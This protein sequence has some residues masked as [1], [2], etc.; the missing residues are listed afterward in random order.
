MADIFLAPQVYNAQRFDYP[1]ERHPEVVRVY[2]NAQKLEA[3]AA[4]YPDRQPDAA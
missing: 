1:M 3:F 4:A 2:E